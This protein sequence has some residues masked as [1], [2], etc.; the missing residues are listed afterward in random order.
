MN[1][2]TSF[3]QSNNTLFKTAVDAYISQGCKTNSACAIGATYGYPIGNWCTSSITSMNSLFSSKNTFNDTISMWDTSQVTNMA[4]MFYGAS[5]FNQAVGSW[6]TSKVT[7]MGYMFN[8]A[9]AFNQ[10]LCQWRSAFR[11]DNAELIFTNS[12]CANKNAPNSSTQQNWCA[13]TTCTPS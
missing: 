2:P 10:N 9:S 7:T 5:A 12:G 13:V 8:Q 6:D 4:E 3:C 1:S 11:Y